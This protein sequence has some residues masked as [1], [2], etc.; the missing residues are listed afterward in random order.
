MKPQ[1]RRNS[2]QKGE[3]KAG[4]KKPPTNTCPKCGKPLRSAICGS[5]GFAD[6]NYLLVAISSEGEKVWQVSVT[7]YCYDDANPG[8]K[9]I[10]AKIRILE[11]GKKIKTVTIQASGKVLEFPFKNKD[12]IVQFSVM[13]VTEGDQSKN[14][15][16]HTESLTLKKKNVRVVLQKPAL[17]PTKRFWGNFMTGFRA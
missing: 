7:I 17:D 3:G 13:K 14:V 1:S 8:G 11:A 12:R 2:G 6:A 5:C 15:N 9:G 10:Q 16:V 4:G